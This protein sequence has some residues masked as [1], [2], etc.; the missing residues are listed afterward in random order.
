VNKVLWKFYR[1]HGER[2]ETLA[3]LLLD[4]L[5]HDEYWIVLQRI[6]AASRGDVA[7]FAEALEAFGLLDLAMIS[8]RARSRLH[9]LDRLDELIGRAETL[10]KDIHKA[11]EQSL[12]VL[13]TKYAAMASNRTLRTIVER[14]LNQQY[15]GK[16][17]DERPDL[18]LAQDAGERYL[19]IELKRPNH[20]LSENDGAQARGYRNELAPH[21]PAK[22][23]DILLLGGRR[24][25]MDTRYDTPDCVYQTYS[26]VISQARFELEW[27]LRKE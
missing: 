22:A 25:Q 3:G 7:Q 9:F 27:L 8:G 1:E 15:S 20:P 14:Y 23:I 26:A 21:L 2:F 16:K 12:W 19:L 5:E 6:D 17:A 24:G 11:L 18:L 4:A 13:G 10:E